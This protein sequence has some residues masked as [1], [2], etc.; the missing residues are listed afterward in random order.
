MQTNRMYPFRVRGVNRASRQRLV[1]ITAIN[2]KNALNKVLALYP[3][4]IVITKHARKMDLIS[5]RV[6]AAK[7]SKQLGKKYY[8]INNVEEEECDVTS[9][10]PKNPKEILGVFVNGSE[11]K[12]EIAI[13]ESTPTKKEKQSVTK[14]E[15]KMST[16]TKTSKKAAK[17]V[18]KKSAPVKKVAVKK[19]ATEA[20]KGKGKLMTIKNI[21]AAVNKGAKAYNRDSK[22]LPI[23]YLNKFA[24]PSKEILATLVE[25]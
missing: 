15:T 25:A 20:P 17:K 9:T 3:V 21:I 2:Y 24:D 12:E 7:K 6:E 1:K 22:P 10:Y 5:A 14:K 23:G 11:V 8:I 4:K 18:A 16:A 19:T 13:E